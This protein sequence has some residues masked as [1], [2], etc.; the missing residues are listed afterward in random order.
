MIDVHVKLPILRRRCDAG[1]RNGIFKQPRISASVRRPTK[2]PR[3]RPVKLRSV[4][5]QR[6][7]LGLVDRGGA[8]GLRCSDRRPI[9]PGRQ[10]F[11]AVPHSARFDEKTSDWPSNSS[12]GSLF[13]ST[14]GRLPATTVRSVE[15]ECDRIAAAVAATA[16]RATAT[17]PVIVRCFVNQNLLRSPPTVCG[18]RDLCKGSTDGRVLL[19]MHLPDNEA[20]QNSKLAP[21]EQARGVERATLIAE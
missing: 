4:G 19:Q 15:G 2:E 11:R 5:Q 8:A 1:G 12:V 16:S 6:I 13:T 21:W 10:A 7:E 9:N 3:F 17:N 14:T 18:S 20:V